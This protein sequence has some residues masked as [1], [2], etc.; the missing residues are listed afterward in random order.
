[1]IY[2]K[3]QVRRKGIHVARFW[4]CRIRHSCRQTWQHGLQIC[5]CVKN[6]K[7]YFFYISTLTLQYSPLLSW[8]RSPRICVF[9]FVFFASSFLKICVFVLENMRF[10]LFALFCVFVFLRSFAFS[11][12]CVFVFLR[13]FALSCK[14]VQKQIHFIFILIL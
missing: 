8:H 4:L 1:M 12:F 6:T 7:Y 9:V 13:F 5:P 11:F 2:F 10:R 3:K 14:L